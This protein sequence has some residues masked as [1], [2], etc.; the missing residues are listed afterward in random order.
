MQISGREPHNL[1]ENAIRCKQGA[2]W[3]IRF[4]TA[5]CNPKHKLTLRVDNTR[6]VWKLEK[7]AVFKVK[8]EVADRNAGSSHLLGLMSFVCC[9]NFSVRPT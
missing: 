7:F 3:T 2:K 9:L 5:V 4:Q 8:R 1:Y 6:P